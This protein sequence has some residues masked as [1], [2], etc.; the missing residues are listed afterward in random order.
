MKENSLLQTWLIWITPYVAH[1]L[2]LYVL[3]QEQEGLLPPSNSI[4]FLHMLF[5]TKERTLYLRVFLTSRN[6]IFV[7]AFWGLS[8]LVSLSS[9]F[10]LSS[11]KCPTYT[12][13]LEFF[14]VYQKW[15]LFAVVFL[16]HYWFLKLSRK[17]MIN[18]CCQVYTGSPEGFCR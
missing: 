4:L 12:N 16:F 15:S 8:L 18:L 13:I 5:Q 2:Y 14:L 6:Y 3:S 7:G 1:L 10:T 17:I 9:A 11:Y